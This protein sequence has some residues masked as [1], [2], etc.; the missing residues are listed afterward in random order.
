MKLPGRMIDL[1]SPLENETVYDPPFMRPK[2]EYRSNADTAPLLLE[3][4][5][6]LRREDLP[7]GEG[8]AIEEI[9]LTTHN[10]TH[11]DAPI[12]VLEN[13]PFIT[14][15]ETWRFF[16]TGVVV[17]IPKGKWGVVTPEDLEKA[18]PK[19]QPGD[20]VMINT[21]S[22]HNW[23]DNPDYFAYSPGLY[24]AAAEWLVARKVKL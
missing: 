22:H 8:W 10:G 18:R 16:G 13:T 7:D 9:K 11:M 19:I 20:I 24:K 4:F 2:I 5:P 12:H 14:E 17:S 1:S 15:Y 3:L 6:G 23:G 21:G